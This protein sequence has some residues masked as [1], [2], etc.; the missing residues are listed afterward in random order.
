M[1]RPS[2]KCA[3]AII[4]LLHILL[5]LSGCSG[6]NTPPTGQEVNAWFQ[7]HEEDLNTVRDYLATL[8]FDSM[9]I[10]YSKMI[11]GNTYIIGYTYIGESQLN[12]TRLPIR[13]D[14]VLLALRSLRKAGC[15]NIYYSR[16]TLQYCIWHGTSSIDCGVAYRADGQMPDI[17]YLTQCEPLEVDGW[18]WYV[19]DFEE[20]RV[21]NAG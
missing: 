6:R 1:M 21:R 5:L 20:W 2:V 15:K 18:Y 7:N 19:A 10:K 12:K 17:A 13:E 8:D 16:N 11:V 3:A 9:D 14:T 4:L